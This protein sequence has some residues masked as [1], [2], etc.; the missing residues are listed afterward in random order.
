M[1]TMQNPIYAMQ[2]AVDAM[3][4]Y[5]IQNLT[6]FKYC[7]NLFYQESNALKQPAFV[8]RY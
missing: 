1:Q 4:K 2:N 5:G 8:H 3:Q 6:N 7:Y